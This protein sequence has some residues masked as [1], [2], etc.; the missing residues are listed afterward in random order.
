VG[1]I[2]SGEESSSSSSDVSSDDG[3]GVHH[4][5]LT[6]EEKANIDPVLLARIE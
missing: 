4:R 3:T 6:P 1:D 5:H 2:T